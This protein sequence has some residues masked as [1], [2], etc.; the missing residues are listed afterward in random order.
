MTSNI[1]SLEEL[2][3]MHDQYQGGYLPLNK[4]ILNL[5]ATILQL[6][7]TAIEY[8]RRWR[9]LA[10]GLDNFTAQIDARL[11]PK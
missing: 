3:Q 4:G 9:V 8:Y 7:E 10:D 2:K 11:S 5:N 1:L 6:C